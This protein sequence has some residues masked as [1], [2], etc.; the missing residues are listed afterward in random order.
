MLNTENR[1]RGIL[2][3]NTVNSAVITVKSVC[4]VFTIGDVLQ[5]ARSY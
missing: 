2:H 4:P 5:N 1:C 3:V